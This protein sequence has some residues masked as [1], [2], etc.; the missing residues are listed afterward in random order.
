MALQVSMDVMLY[1]TLPVLLTALRPCTVQTSVI[2]MMIAVVTE[3]FAEYGLGAVSSTC[4]V[5]HTVKPP[6]TLAK[7]LSV[8]G[9]CWQELCR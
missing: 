1:E 8:K 6:C 2:V 9:T 7:P 5:S 3:V 4:G